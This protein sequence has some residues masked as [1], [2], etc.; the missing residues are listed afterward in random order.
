MSSNQHDPV[1]AE[2]ARFNM[3]AQ[4][5]RP[6]EVIDERVLAVLQEL[7]RE[8]FVPREYRGL[9]FA[10]FEIPVAPGRFMLPPRVEGRLLQALQVHPAERVLEIGTGSGFVTAC[11]A[12][13]GGQVTSYDPDAQ[14]SGAAA[15]RLTALG[16]RNVTLRVGD[17]LVEDLPKGHYGV[18][19]VTAGLPRLPAGLVETL[20][21]GGRLFAVVGTPPAME[22]VLLTKV[23]ED[24]VRQENLFE[25]ELPMLPGTQPV[26]RF[27]F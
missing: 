10:D 22:A 11:L 14:L 12:R 2:R 23:R 19:A 9:A 1:S 7:P 8:R 15:E 4:Q 21:T 3:A 24:V 27:Q 25:T 16:I 13:L 17:P 6:W 18:I 20:G 26:S 5:L